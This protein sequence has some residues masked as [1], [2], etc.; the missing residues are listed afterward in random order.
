MRQSKR[1]FYHQRTANCE[2]DE[3]EY[4]IWKH[5][6]L[7]NKCSVSNLLR[8]VIRHELQILDSL[9]YMTARKER[10]KAHILLGKKI[11]IAASNEPIK[12]AHVMKTTQCNK[13]DGVVCTADENLIIEVCS[14]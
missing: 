6:A 8:G 13:V 4:K 7:K 1:H 10:L 9:D 14:K 2:I 3:A 11:N 5:Y 12:M